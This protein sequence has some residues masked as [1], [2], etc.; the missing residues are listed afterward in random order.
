MWKY[1]FMNRSLSYGDLFFEKHS[2]LDY[3]L[4][5][6]QLAGRLKHTQRFCVFYFSLRVHDPYSNIY[7][8]WSHSDQ[9][10]R[11][12]YLNRHSEEHHQFKD[13]IWYWEMCVCSIMNVF[14]IVKP[15]VG[16]AKVFNKSSTKQQVKYIWKSSKGDIKTEHFRSI[17]K[18]QETPT[19]SISSRNIHRIVLVWPCEQ[20]ESFAVYFLLLSR[21]R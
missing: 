13:F 17:C 18:R 16:H 21:T 6:Q 12:I 20:L 11:S 1:I 5:S 8:N 19:H 4:H 15:I 2:Q 10:I 7:L 3:F 9:G 14:F